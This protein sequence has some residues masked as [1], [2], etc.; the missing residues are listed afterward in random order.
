MVLAELRFL[1]QD[2]LRMMGQAMRVKH[3]TFSFGNAR[4]FRLVVA[5]FFAPLRRPACKNL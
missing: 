2:H 4:L 5:V 3:E 1:W